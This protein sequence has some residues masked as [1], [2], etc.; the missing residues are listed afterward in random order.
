[1]SA[2]SLAPALPPERLD[3]LLEQCAGLL[4]EV[5]ALWRRNALARF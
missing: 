5:G 3:R 4:G 2:L 1:M